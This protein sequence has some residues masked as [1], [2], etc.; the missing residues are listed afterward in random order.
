MKKIFWIIIERFLFTARSS[1]GRLYF[2]YTKDY[3][4]SP[5]SITREFFCF[6]LEDTAR[7]SNIKVYGETCLPGGLECDVSLF[8][9]DHFK[10][11]IIFHTE[12]DK[13]TITMGPLKWVGCLAHNGVTF[14][15]TEGCTLVGAKV[16]DPTY[17]DRK[18]I[19]EP[20]LSIG[21]KDQLRKVI[22]SRINQGYIV[23]ARFIN[24]TQS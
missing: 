22:E 5:L 23:K 11:T 12:D 18:I 13:A 24:L 17:K 10:K 8:E 1:V 20:V 3:V 21:R 4:S 7:P 19:T 15:H 14:E 16:I 6:T 9:N 2:E